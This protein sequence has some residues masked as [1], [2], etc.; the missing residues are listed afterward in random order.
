MRR[1]KMHITAA[2]LATPRNG[3]K[4][5]KFSS[6]LLIGGLARHAFNLVSYPTP[7]APA[8]HKQKMRH[9]PCDGPVLAFPVAHTLSENVA[10]LLRF[11]TLP[12]QHTQIT[13]RLTPVRRFHPPQKDCRHSPSS[14]FE[15]MR[16]YTITEYTLLPRS[17][18]KDTGLPPVNKSLVQD[19]R[20]LNFRVASRH[21][22]NAL[23]SIP[24][25]S[26]F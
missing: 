10:R 21:L 7:H 22:S 17:W 19:R 2:C 12:V 13:N 16:S 11:V 6:S 18:L 14:I 23:S 5:P 25:V 24:S 3:S 20:W 15:S 8:S 1:W 4:V 26:Y 9:C